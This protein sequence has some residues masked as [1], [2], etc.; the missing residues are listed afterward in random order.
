MKKRYC[1]FAKIRDGRFYLLNFDNESIID[2]LEQVPP[3]EGLLAIANWPIDKHTEV[4]FFVELINGNI[5]Y[6][7]LLD[8]HLNS[9]ETVILDK[10][11]L[12]H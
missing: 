9:K 3:P 7:H 5:L 8:R 10:T 1:I 12:D 4:E 2:C 6:Y 11:E